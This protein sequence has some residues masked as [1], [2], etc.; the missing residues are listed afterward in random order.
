MKRVLITGS[1]GFI[2]RALAGELK[3]RRPNLRVFGLDRA[4]AKGTIACD[5]T[6]AAAA[7]RAVKACRPNAIFHL[8][9]SHRRLPWGELWD[10][11]VTATVNLLEAA[12]GLNPPPKVLIAGSCA[13][14][15]LP[16]S[17]GRVTEKRQARP[18]SEY[19][20]SKLCQTLAALAYVHLG[21]PVVGVRL[22]NLLG[23]GTPEALAPGA[24]AGQIARIESGRQKPIVRTGNLQ[25]RRD[26]LDVRD[27]ASAMI[28]ALESGRPGEVYNVCSGVSRPM[29]SVLDALVRF[30]EKDI[31]IDSTGDGGG[32]PDMTGSNKLLSA[33]TP[34]RPRFSFE[35]SVKDTLD[36]HRGLLR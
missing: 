31:R 22:F 1:R 34:W 20:A 13:E 14:Y 3:R 7:R 29:R 17:T 5:L 16:P 12:R 24:F 28:D 36:W 15:G 25:P 9:G 2:G 4:P 35:R 19:G 32:V 27:A 33:R 10:T 26:Y 8:A 18:V 30:S 11:H 23:P 21:V 6:N